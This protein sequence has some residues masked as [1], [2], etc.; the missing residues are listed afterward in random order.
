MTDNNKEYL[1]VYGTL[2]RDIGNDMYHLL[3]KHAKYID[4]ATWSGKLYLVET[5]PGAVRSDNPLD[6][7][8]GEVFLLNNPDNVLPGLDEYEECSDNFPEPKLYKRIKDKVHLATG[9]IINAWIYIYNLPVDNLKEI[10]SGNFS[11]TE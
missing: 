7:V 6:A 10:K 2:K 11:Q 8:H 9:D 5:Y 1:F 4:D 3:A